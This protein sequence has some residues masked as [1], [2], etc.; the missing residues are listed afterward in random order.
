MR[1]SKQG[2]LLS[3]DT[4]W[5]PGREGR[6]V[7]IVQ[8]GKRRRIAIFS[9]KLKTVKRLFLSKLSMP[10]TEILIRLVNRHYSR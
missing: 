7:R 8:S 9:L 2:E 3:W 10:M 1:K 5:N 4:A 6:M